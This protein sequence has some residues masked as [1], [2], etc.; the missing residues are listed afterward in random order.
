[1]NFYSRAIIGPP[2]NVSPNKTEVQNQ[3]VTSWDSDW[4]FSSA[5]EHLPS[6]L[7]ALRCSPC[8]NG[9]RTEPLKQEPA[10]HEDIHLQSQHSGGRAM[11]I[12]VSQKPAWSTQRNPVSKQTN[13]QQQNINET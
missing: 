3:R 13:K 10:G 4:G 6:M 2:N 9:Q 5:A 11:W 12:S 7:S 8:S 1:M